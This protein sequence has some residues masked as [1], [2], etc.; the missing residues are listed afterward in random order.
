M[1]TK[2]IT[3]KTEELRKQVSQT[4]ESITRNKEDEQ[5]YIVKEIKKAIKTHRSN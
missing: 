1:K 3:L 4:F 2:T 5:K